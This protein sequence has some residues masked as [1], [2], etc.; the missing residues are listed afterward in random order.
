MRILKAGLYVAAVVA[1]AYVNT[2]SASRCDAYFPFDGTLADAT[3]NGYDGLMIAESGAA[4][5]QFG[6]GRFGE[7]LHISGSSAMRSFLDLHHETCPQFTITAWFRLPSVSAD[8]AQAILST[9]AS[10]ANPGL[11]ASGSSL[12]LYGNGNGLSQRNAIRNGDTWYFMAATF[13]YG[14]REYKLHWRNRT[15]DGRL[16][17]SPYDAEDSFWI[18]TRS[19]N[20]RLA[21]QD[22]YIDDVRVFGRV[23]SADEIRDLSRNEAPGNALAPQ[24]TRSANIDLSGTALESDIPQ[25]VG[26]ISES[27]PGF[28]TR[29]DA[30]NLDR[31]NQPPDLS[32]GTQQGATVDA[33]LQGP[34]STTPGLT[35]AEN[36]PGAALEENIQRARETPPDLPASVPIDE[37]DCE[38]R[39]SGAIAAFRRS[40]DIPSE[41]TVALRRAQGCE[42]PVR[43]ASLNA[44]GQWIVATNEAIAVSS[45]APAELRA[46]ARDFVAEHGGLTAGDIAESGAWMIAAG[47]RV[48]SDGLPYQAL[49]A[50]GAMTSQGREIYAFDFKPNNNNQWIMMDRNGNF[51]GFGV[52]ADMQ[53]QIDLLPLSRRSVH[54]VKFAPNGGWVLIGS[55]LW[56]SSDGLPDGVLDDLV[57][58]RRAGRRVDHIVFSGSASDYLTFSP[59]MESYGNN[60]IAQIEGNVA[61]GT[62]WS[63][64]EANNLAAVSIAVV[65]NNQI[66]WQRGYGLRNPND[67]ESY[68]RIDTTF[69]AASISKPIA[70]FGLL[71]LVEE[72]RLS[73]TQA[74]VLED[75]EQ[76]IPRINRPGFRDRVRPEAGNLIQVL[77][78][79][80][81]ICYDGISNCGGG[82]EEYPVDEPIPTMA[83]MLRG[84]GRADRNHRP[85][86]IQNP[87]IASDYSSANWMLVQ[88]LIEVHGGGFES[89]MGQ[90]LGDIGT[91]SSTYRSPYPRRNGGNFARG[92]TGS[93]ITPMYA[94]GEMAAASLVATPADI[95]R[96]V[97]TVN[98]LAQTP[99]RTTPLSSE[100]T[101]RMIGRN[102]DI[103]APQQYGTCRSPMGF[104]ATERWGLG[105]RADQS[106]AGWNGNE[107]FTHGGVH[108]GYRTQMFGFPQAGSGL[109][110]FMTGNRS[111]A[112]S[113]FS[114]LRQAFRRVYF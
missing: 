50:V 69:D 88:G 81:S 35:G 82:A 40:G 37:L 16:S 63:A 105:L 41:F 76:L 101:N 59:R 33:G 20:L 27:G 25:G 23:L 110:V 8:G 34:I 12:R 114:S 90:L 42:Q 77:Q 7:A 99:G 24:T 89:H 9:G 48:E 100:M 73:L 111:Q 39:V 104:S 5:P 11:V 92:W 22:L 55:H 58:W 26:P 14:A 67:R 51:E 21:A 103:Y 106:G 31:S 19:D 75:L 18:G 79:C 66:Q 45:N 85:V 70:T 107:Y 93:Q 2:A 54:Q 52:P 91:T 68:V 49:N 65:V 74:G 46:V 87:G 57:S 56:F 15:V 6:E 113:F 4:E 30:S 84:S 109:V 108:N 62:I 86:R 10:G 112:N 83:Q 60:P 47:T 3:G 71:Q 17:D 97:I 61:G 36:T 96:F 95:A 38:T 43:V 44:S 32:G 94:Y 102:P 72:G 98:E 64:M 29:I 78:H 53:E 28:D 1:A 80:A 13:D